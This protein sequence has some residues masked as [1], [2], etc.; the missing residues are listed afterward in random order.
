MWSLTKSHWS[1]QNWQSL[2]LCKHVVFEGIEWRLDGSSSGKKC[3]CGVQCLS[4]GNWFYELAQYC[5]HWFF[6]M[7]SSE[8]ICGYQFSRFKNSNLVQ[9]W[10]C[11]IGQSFSFWYTWNVSQ[12]TFNYNQ[13]FQDLHPLWCFC[14]DGQ[15]RW[16]PVKRAPVVKV[17]VNFINRSSIWHLSLT[18]SWKNQLLFSFNQIYSSI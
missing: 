16:G 14:V 11:L 13:S 15:L 10:V 1:P 9:G 2:L 5:K 8:R 12:R 17:H 18:R 3:P 6:R 4:V 7:L